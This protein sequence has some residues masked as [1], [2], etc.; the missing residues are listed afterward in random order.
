MITNINVSSLKD[1]FEEALFKLHTQC[2]FHGQVNITHSYSD[3][4]ANGWTGNTSVVY[5]AQYTQINCLLA[6]LMICSLRIIPF[7]FN[8]FCVLIINML[9]DDYIKS[10]IAKTYSEYNCET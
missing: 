10:P 5:D 4:L 1:F 9:S 2:H 7:Y 6:F 3:Q 8:C